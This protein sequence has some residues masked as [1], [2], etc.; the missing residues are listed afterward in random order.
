VSVQIFVEGGGNQATTKAMCRKGFSDYCG[1]IASLRHNPRIVACGSRDEAF[2]K[3]CI[4]VSESRQGEKVVLLVDSE[5][6]IVAGSTIEHLSLRDPSWNFPRLQQHRTF[7]M[8]QTMEAWLLADR[9]ILAEFYDGGYLPNALPQ[10]PSV[11]N[12]SKQDLELGLK[13]ATRGTKSKGEYH[14]TKHG[15]ALLS[16]IDPQKVESASPHAA[17]F[18][19]FLRSV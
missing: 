3:F 5:E 13:N 10:N 4:A 14:K 9:D 17:S 15:F 7:L 18:H 11:E 19:Q 1:R 12:I 8:V 16:L 2:K 6:A